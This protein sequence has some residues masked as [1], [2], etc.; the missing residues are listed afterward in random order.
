MPHRTSRTGSELF[1]V[2]NSDQDWK[3]LRYLH[4]W[5]Q[6]SQAIDIATGY[7]EI[8]ALLGLKDEWQKV[9][10]IRI[11]MGDEVTL[12]TKAAFV[13]GLANVR[14][15]LDASLEAEKLKNDFLLGV[16]A[17]VD[18]I[19][20]ARI[21]CRVYRKE[22]FHAKAY[23]THARLE[24]VGSSGL[25]G[26]SNFTDPGLTE[27]IE[28]NVQITGRPVT[29]L[30]EWYEEHWNAAED[31]TPEILR[32]I[33]RHIREYTPF[34]VYAKAL[35][36]LHRR[37]ELTDQ[38][39]LAQESRVYGVL[40]QYQKDGFHKLLEIAD[41]HGGAFL[42]DGVGLGKT[43][44]GL[45]L[46]EYL[47]E[48]KRKRIAL[49]V[50]KAARKPVWEK[51]LK[52][53][54]PH[55]RG[56]YSGLMI[57]N[58]T[59]LTRK[60]NDDTDYP[61]LLADV[62]QRADVVLIDEAHHFR[63][64]GYA[65]TGRGMLQVGESDRRRSRY[66][67]LFDLIDG[68]DGPKQVFL[69]TATPVNNR[70]LDVQHMIELF[71]RRQPDHFKN[72]GIHSLPGHVRKMEKEL[73]RAAA[74]GDGEATETNLAE[75]GDLLAGDALFRALVVQRS[76]AYVC[77]S[78]QL[79]G[80][81]A[82]VFPAREAPTVAA[83]SVKK[84]YGRLLDMVEQA[85]S[86]QKPLFSLA[87]Y[88][89]LAY[90]KG[91]DTTIDPFVEG[92]QK[93]IVGLIRTQ[94]LKRFESSAHAFEL[95]CDRLLGKL[96]AFVTKHSETASEKNTLE[97]WRLRN[98]ELVAYV[99]ERQLE[100][101]PEAD[102]EDA[103]E[104]LVTEEMLEAVPYLPRDEYDVESILLE[105]YQDLDQIAD[106]LNEL[107]KFQPKHDDK[108]K[109]LGKLLQTDPVLKRHKVLIFSE[110]AETARYLKQQLVALG[111]SGVEQ[112]DS[113]TKADRGEVIRRFAPYYNGSSS[114]ELA[115][116]GLT[117]TRVLISTDVLSEGLN[118]Q[119]A[120]RL[121]NYDLHWNPVRLMQRIGRVDRRLNPDVE[122]R[123][124]ADHPEATAVRGTVAYWN[125]LPPDELNALL[126]LYARVT[127]KTLRISKTFGIEGKKLLTP[128]DD[129]EA[130]KNFN[131]QYEGEPN[132]AERLQLE[133][134]ALV[135][136]DPGLEE[137]LAGL[138]GRV[139]SGQRHRK[140]GARAVFFCFALPAADHGAGPA[141]ELPW[142][143]E[144]GR[145]AWYLYDLATGQVLEDPA[146]IVE[147]I[148]CQP[149]TPRHCAVEKETLAEI[150]AQVERHIKNTYLKS[151]QAPVGVKPA[152]KAWMELN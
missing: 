118:L 100:L 64:P 96:L 119:D 126:T 88:Y 142:T 104:D 23:I 30:Q 40:D 31:V 50:P 20:S 35:H 135:A 115:A 19:R 58:H 66:H 18:A 62:R 6:I 117:E 22:K 130:L 111:I 65:G 1:I 32:V 90:Y 77:Q 49:F 113:G 122:K 108:L 7:F 83:Y 146:K 26:S 110:F 139:F 85:F 25:V 36:E 147:V 138:P 91:D 128:E 86:K 75:A 149:D 93:Q 43:F 141:G 27:N 33:E 89:P 98:K 57:F 39:W 29:V 94:F 51:A 63:N 125:F 41:R 120:T 76:R 79:Q 28:L 103:E 14:N 68:L 124:V 5:C 45:M 56:A 13:Q 60:G 137:R 107:R 12:R 74:A 131:H 140:A 59:D 105:T 78:Q 52:D 134:D 101:F 114:P 84:T 47:I 46:L 42:C 71:S 150:R 3:V 136:A 80:T 144:A 21:V 24:V 102:D 123:L 54:A 15:R 143:E 55:L 44:I 87:I 16:P 9:D 97:R 34:E 2:D 61:R 72:L 106:F 92:R 109:A 151:V 112:I 67:E 53:Y 70:L 116:E 132:P 17:I 10:C 133:Y 38:Q 81:A 11:L 37:Q 8:G 99:H 73:L 148:R 129:Y 121:I 48:H 152:L 145:A 4:D 82:A 95:S 69:L 127:H